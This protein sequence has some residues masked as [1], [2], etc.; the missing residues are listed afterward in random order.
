M[1]KVL[2]ISYYEL[3]EH[4]V[5]I[6]NNFR[7]LYNWSVINYPLYM[8][9]YDSLSKVNNVTEHLIDYLT[10]EKPHIVLWW[11][12]DIYTDFFM[13]IKNAFP[14]IYY[15]LYCLDDP[16]KVNFTKSVMFTHLITNDENSVEKYYNKY[17]DYCPFCYDEMFFKNVKKEYIIDILYICENLN[18]DINEIQIIK[19]LNNYCLENDL[20]LEIY[21]TPLINDISNFYKGYVVYNDLPILFNTSKIVFTNKFS[22]WI[23]SIKT[24]NTVLIHDYT[25]NNIIHKLECSYPKDNTDII[26]S[27]NLSVKNYTWKKLTDIIFFRYNEYAFNEKKY[28]N[29][30]SYWLEQWNKGIYEIPYDIDI[31]DNFDSDTYIVKNNLTDLTLEYVYIHW[32]KHSNDKIYLKK[33]KMLK[34]VSTY[35]TIQSSVYDIYS[36]FNKIF[37]SLD[38]DNGLT[39]LDN[40]VKQHKSLKIN[41][42]LEAYFN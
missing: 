21:G 8:Y 9:C 33:H 3:K 22:N 12:S 36:V 16:N 20:K 4:F 14:N 15:I 13:Q 19:I 24:C 27:N 6:A 26:K 17:V 7:T 11:F 42:L 35:N 28:N 40:I 37:V 29:T 31:P 38:I 25:K 2:I 41:D 23:T 5:S 1:R 10:E 39:N 34:D 32:L 18:S 30:Y